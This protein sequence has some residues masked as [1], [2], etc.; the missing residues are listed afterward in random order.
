MRRL[1]QTSLAPPLRPEVDLSERDSLWH[2][3]EKEAGS[4]ARLEMSVWVH[5]LAVAVILL[6]GLALFFPPLWVLV[7]LPALAYLSLREHHYHRLLTLTLALA[8][9]DDAR[10]V[11]PLISLWCRTKPW[12]WRKSGCLEGELARLLSHFVAQGNLILSWQVAHGLYRRMA[13]LY[14]RRS[15]TT[16]D[17]TD[18]SDARADLMVSLVHLLARS[19]NVY[20]RAV[21]ERIASGPARSPRRILVRDVAREMLS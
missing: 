1:A 6:G 7:L 13:R 19:G 17:L 5:L 20:D 8:E 3:I 14:P 9:R 4:L 21:L 18:M 11:G 15:F 2:A 16:M 10:A 12:E